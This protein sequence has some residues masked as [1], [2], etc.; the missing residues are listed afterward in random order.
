MKNETQV[1]TEPSVGVDFE[2]MLDQPL[3]PRAGRGGG[4]NDDGRPTHE[5]LVEDNLKL[6]AMACMIEV[7]N[8]WCRG[9]RGVVECACQLAMSAYKVAGPKFQ[10]EK[11]RGTLRCVCGSH[12]CQIGPFV[13][14]HDRK[15]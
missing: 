9:E 7:D 1:Q 13:V 14:L 11:D 4:V 3:Q 15:W 5:K 2:A 6:L 8:A 12:M 10:A